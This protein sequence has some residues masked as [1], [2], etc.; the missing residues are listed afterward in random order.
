MIP[1]RDTIPHER[2]PITTT[3]LIALNILAFIY[4]LSLGPRER[5]A[6]FYLFGLV[7]ARYTQPEWAAAVGLSTSFLPV[8]TGIF[9]HG[10][11]MHL[12]GNIW[13]LWI[14]GDNVEDRM[15]HVKFL[16][17]YLFCGI[18]ASLLHLSLHAASRIPT[19]GASG[20]IAGVLGAYFLMYPRAR[21]VA[22]IP[23]FI[24]LQMVEIP[25]FV[26][27]GLWFVM[28]FLSAT[29]PAASVSGVAFWAHVGGFL[30]G[31]FTYRL[32]LRRRSRRGRA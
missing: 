9:L 26:F 23:I 17:F 4:E 12:I 21:V 7:P 6:L 31:L 32:F 22:L 25:A 3:M 8:L 27:L 20:A 1:L 29:S 10:G 14:F 5:E 15:G 24:F 28:Q 13:F 19:I 16:F 18:V 11:W 2:M 30:A